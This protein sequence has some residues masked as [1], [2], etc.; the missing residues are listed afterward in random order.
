[1]VGIYG[2]GVKQ[3]NN[4]IS[5]N[6]T[7][8]FTIR[9]SQHFSS[10]REFQMGNFQK[11]WSQVKILLYLIFFTG[12]RFWKLMGGT[13]GILKIVR[14]FFSWGEIVQEINVSCAGDPVHAGDKALTRETPVQR[15]RVNRYADESQFILFRPDG[16]CCVYQH[17]GER[18]ADACIH[19]RDMFGGGSLMVWGGISHGLKSPL[20]VIAGNL[21]G[22]R[23]RDEILRPV[24][25]PFV[26]Q[27]HL[28][29]QQDNVRPCSQSLSRFSHQS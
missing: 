9:I 25:V 21:T 14:T 18:F 7:F 26:Q 3:I 27:H 22:V 1:M 10:A 15:G 28:I 16:R 6:M 2:K 11:Y 4:R 5:L 29:F 17:C 24:A 19:E 12:G 20:I 8:T 13:E 23:Y